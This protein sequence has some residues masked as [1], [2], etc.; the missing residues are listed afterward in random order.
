GWAVDDYDRLA[1]G[2]LAGHI[3]ECGAQATGGLFTDWFD[4]PDWDNIGYPIVT[5]EPTGA[6]T[7]SKPPGTGGIVTRGA[8]ADQLVYEIGDPAA[9]HLPD[10]TCD[11]T[12]VHIEEA[13]E[14][15]VR[16][17]GSRGYAPSSSYKISATYQDGWRAVAYLTIGGI[18]ARAK[19][20]RT[21][22]AILSR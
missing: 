21:A 10:V 1:A 7:V 11:F 5:V 8:I 9:Y 12:A 18:D 15:L 13:G 4:V 6:F 17:S 2:S 14:D 20:Q 22:E 3:I 19:A 16:V